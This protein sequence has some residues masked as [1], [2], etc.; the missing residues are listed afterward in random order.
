MWADELL[1]PDM[2]LSISSHHKMQGATDSATL[3][4]CRMFCSEDP[5]NPEKIFPISNFNNGKFQN[6]EIPL[7]N[8]DFPAPCIPTNKIPLG[9][10]GKPYNAASSEKASFLFSSQFFKPSRPPISFMSISLSTQS[11]KP[12]FLMMSFL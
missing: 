2:P 7:A 8:K 5:T 6:E 10:A 4:T 11:S 1:D 12:D 3:N 9:L